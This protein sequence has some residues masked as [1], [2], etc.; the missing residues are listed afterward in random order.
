[1]NIALWITQILLVVVFGYS[2]LIKGTQSTE[3]ALQL[4]HDRRRELTASR[5]AIHRVLRGAW[6]WGS[7]F[8]RHRGAAD[9]PRWPP[10]D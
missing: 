7:S 8:Q 6:C 10:S 9:P 1:M 5:N 4:G 3:R 2:A